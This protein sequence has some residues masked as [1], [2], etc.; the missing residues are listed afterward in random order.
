MSVFLATGFSISDSSLALA[1]DAP[2]AQLTG[3]SVSS[4]DYHS[5]TIGWDDPQ[6]DSITGYQILLRS[7]DGDTYGDGQGAWEFVAIEDDTGTA[8]TE[9][10]D[11]SVSPGRRYVYRVKA[12][13]SAGLGERSSYANAETLGPPA[14]P[15]GLAVASTNHDSITIV[16]DDPQDDSITGYQILRRSRDGDTYGDGQ[17]AWE[18]VAIEDD[19]GAADAEYTDSS[20]TPETRYVYRVK[21]RN[22]AGLSERSSYANAETV[23]AP[24]PVTEPTPTPGPKDGGGGG[25]TVRQQETSSDAGL[26]SLTVNGDAIPGVDPDTT[27]YTLAV[28]NEVSLAI[29]VAETRHPMAT[30]A[31]ITLH[32]TEPEGLNVDLQPGIPN[33]I[34]LRVTAEDGV[35]SQ[36]Y[37]LT[38]NRG[39]VDATG[40]TVLKDL[41]NVLGSGG[42]F[43]GGIWSDETHIWV[44]GGDDLKLY[45]Y[46][47]A[48]KERDSKRDIALDS[49]NADPKGI[50]S[51]RETMWVVDSADRD[52]YA[53]N[54]QSGARDSSKD[55]IDLGDD[56]ADYYGIWSDGETIWLSDKIGPAIEAFD[57][58]TGEKVPALSY[59]HLEDS[60]HD[61]VAGI[62]SDGATMLV[63]SPLPLTGV[64]IVFGDL[65]S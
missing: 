49:D 13:N 5:I 11:T 29:L 42:D 44:S 39:S 54:L 27:K 4:E 46:L 35:T 38:I 48:T 53:Y 55:F 19:T 52:L 65:R 51:D 6:D 25:N 12:R 63:V 59:D 56:D 8:D 22:P 24:E 14:Q 15:T 28:G 57:F 2:P 7:R 40:W 62:W 21:A 9:Y 33:T 36:V 60:A 43:P 17:G 10:T 64:C 45:A 18:F 34:E 50:W 47:L 23:A 32:L 61:S 41:D 16:W 1:Q 58:D 3:L 31:I 20:V 30:V 26:S 37:T